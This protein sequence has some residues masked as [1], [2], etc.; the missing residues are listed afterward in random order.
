MTAPD[1]LRYTADHHWLRLEGKIVTVG[2]TDH[3]QSELSDVVFV[4]L[5]DMGDLEKGSVCGVIESVKAASDVYAPDSGEVVEIKLDLVT[6]PAK[7][8]TDPYDGGWIFKMKLNDTAQV[9][10]LLDASS[11]ITTVR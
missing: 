4:E 2:V 3:A 10:A 5:P 7:I 11:Y 1:N 6:D 8:N 9:E